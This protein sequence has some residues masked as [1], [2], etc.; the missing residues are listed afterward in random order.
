M[1][2]K[3]F[4]IFSTF[5]FLC[6]VKTFSQSA[7]NIFGKY[8]QKIEGKALFKGEIIFG[9][10]SS[11]IYRSIGSIK[12]STDGKFSI[13]NDTIFLK[14]SKGFTE[15]TFKEIE[16]RIKPFPIEMFGPRLEASNRPFRLFWNKR[17][18]NLIIASSLESSQTVPYSRSL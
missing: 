8:I 15:N 13:I 12:D 5:F 9:A 3:V 4:F 10:D 11:F 18:D 2:F 14:Y 1:K 6:S 7:E 16:N 17:I